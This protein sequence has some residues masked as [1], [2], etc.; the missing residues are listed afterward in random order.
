MHRFVC[1][2][3]VEP[4]AAQRLPETLWRE[5]AGRRGPSLATAEAQ[6]RIGRALALGFAAGDVVRDPD[7]SHICKACSPFGLA[8]PIG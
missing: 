2:G 1:S 5:L 6:L 8:Q 4:P 7:P 3:R